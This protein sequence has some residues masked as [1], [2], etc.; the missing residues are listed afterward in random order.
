VLLTVVARLVA[1]KNLEL[2]AALIPRTLACDPGAKFIILAAAPGGDADALALQGRLRW[3]AQSHPGRVYYGGAFNPPLAKLILAGGDFALIPSRFEPCGLVDYEASL[4]G[5]IVIGHRVGGLDKV[6]HCAY[7][8]EWLDVRDPVGEAEAFFRAVQAALS[9]YRNDPPRH[10]ELMRTAMAL[11]AGWDASA[12]RYIELYRFGFM[13]RRWRLA[14]AGL[15]EKFVPTL[16]Q[17]RE[18]FGR[19]FNPGLAEYADRCDWELKERL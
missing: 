10:A 13:A 15:I 16:G 2:V 9:V 1:Q 19:F 3:L 14:R 7:L 11:N 12:D 6:R 8:Y 18:L 17:D 4:L 5:A